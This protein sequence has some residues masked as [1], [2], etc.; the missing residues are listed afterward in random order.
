MYKYTNYKISYTLNGKKESIEYWTG[1]E[2]TQQLTSIVVFRKYFDAPYAEDRIVAEDE[3]AKSGQAEY[4]GFNF[5]KISWTIIEERKMLN[6]MFRAI[7]NKRNKENRKT[8]VNFMSRE[9]RHDKAFV[10]GAYSNNYMAN[11]NYY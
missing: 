4:Q 7:E 8:Q 6:A 2:M 9:K 1:L 5:S 3:L 11:Y 10:N